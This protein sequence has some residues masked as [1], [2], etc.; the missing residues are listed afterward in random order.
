MK[1]LIKPGCLAEWREEDDG[2]GKYASQQIT[3]RH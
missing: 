3:G 2:R 1:S